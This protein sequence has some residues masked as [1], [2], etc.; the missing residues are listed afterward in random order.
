MAK[1][2]LNQLLTRLKQLRA[3]H[4]LSQE[5]FAELAGMSY[6][7]YQALEA[8]RKQEVRFSTL[9]RV[10]DTYGIEVYELLGPKIPQT[11]L[12]KTFVRLRRGR[13]PKSEKRQQRS[14]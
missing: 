9:I 13:P 4:G 6:K 12:K 11:N 3:K 1:A 7:H 10:A 2:A 14:K 8:G 5:A